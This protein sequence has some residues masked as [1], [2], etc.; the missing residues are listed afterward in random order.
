MRALLF[1][2]LLPA[3]MAC[4]GP[5]TPADTAETPAADT[6][7]AI[8][9]PVDLASHGLPL[10]LLPPDP[11][12]TDGAQPTIVWKDGPGVLEIKAG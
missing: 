10:L 1:W 8:A 3:L 11:T 2:T 5:T 4:S 7:A 9:A 12:L 6:A